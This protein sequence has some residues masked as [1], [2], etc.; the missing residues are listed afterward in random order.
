MAEWKPNEEVLEDMLKKLEARPGYMA[1]FHIGG[2]GTYGAID[3]ANEIV[4]GT[5]GG[6]TIYLRALEYNYL[7]CLKKHL[8]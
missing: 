6:R 3:I 7:E 4:L 8:E 2:A 5:D 1:R